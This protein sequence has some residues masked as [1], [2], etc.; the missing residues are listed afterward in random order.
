MAPT[1]RPRP[2]GPTRR[3]PSILW[4]VAAVLLVARIALGVVE[5]RNPPARRDLVPWVPALDAPAQA[6]ATG[7]PVFYDFSAEWCGP[8][9]QMEE[10]LFSDEKGARTIARLSVP[11]HVVDRQREDGRNSPVVDSLQRAF[12]VTAFPTL[13]VTDAD[14]KVIDKLEGYPGANEFSQWLGRASV[15]HQMSGKGGPALTFP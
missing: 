7:R 8:C 9:V 6:R 11:V 15:K 2:T 12:A 1:D 13:V 10:Q 14:G 5:A 3:D 4:L